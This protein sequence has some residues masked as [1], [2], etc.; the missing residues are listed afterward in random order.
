MYAPSFVTGRLI[1]RFGVV[2][3]GLLG[4]A[5]FLACGAVAEAGISVS[6]FNIA[7]TLLGIG[8][9]FT[10]L[11]ATATVANLTWPQERAKV[12]ATNDFI[13]FGGTAF[14]AY[15]SGVLLSVFGW[16]GIAAMAFPAACLGAALILV[17]LRARRFA[18]A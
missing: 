18:V 6:H 8:W 15:F 13:V 2:R 12:Q 14:A 10:F 1:A 9:N 4:C 7:L 16:N 3:I 11:S 17:S 5:I